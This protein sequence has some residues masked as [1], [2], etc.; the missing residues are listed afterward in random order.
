V[1]QMAKKDKVARELREQYKAVITANPD[2]PAASQFRLTHDLSPNIAPRYPST[3]HSTPQ[4][5]NASDAS[6][7]PPSTQTTPK[8][9]IKA[10]PVVQNLQNLMVLAVFDALFHDVGMEI[11][12]PQGRKMRLLYAEYHM[13]YGKRS[14]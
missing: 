3:F 9:L 14:L 13:L 6:L 1:E 8:K 2:E 5:R 4:K 10:E 7:D 11:K 12:W